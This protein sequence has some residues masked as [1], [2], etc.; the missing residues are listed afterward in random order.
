MARTHRIADRATPAALRSLLKAVLQSR[1]N[2]NGYSMPM[3]MV[4]ALILIVGG[5]AIASR[6]NQGLL[7]AIFQNQSWEAREAAEIGMNRLISDLNRERNRWLMVSR[8]G[9][10]EGTS[11]DTSPW[12]KPASGGSID[13]T[14]RNPCNPETTADYSRLDPSNA[15]SRTYGN[16]Y[17]KND[18][19]VS[20]SSSSATRSYRLLAVERQSMAAMTDLSPFRDR[21]ALPSGVG[22]ITLRV[23]GQKLNSSGTAV[24]TV[25][26]EKTFELVPKCCR[27]S[28][29]G[30][31]GALD[32]QL[33][34]S[35]ESLCVDPTQLGMGLLAGAAQNNTGSITLRGA[36]TDIQTSAGVT[37]DPIYC[38]AD[39]EAGCAISV[40][41][42]QPTGV[43]VV[44]AELPPVKTYPSTPVPSPGSIDTSTAAQFPSTP[45][46]GASA[47]S[48]RFLYQAGSGGS[49][50]YVVNGSFTSA[51]GFPSFCSST[52]TEVHCNLTSF[53]YKNNPV[54]FVTGTRKLRFYFPN[55]G[56]V[57]SQ[58][59]N[60][61]LLHCLTL[62]AAGTCATTPSGAQITNL[63]LFGCSSCSSQSI[64]LRGT[65][66]TLR[67]FSYFPKGNIS[68]YGNSQFEGISWSNQLSS[69]GNPTW[70]VPGS[71]LASVYEYMGMLPASS[72]GSSTS[73]L[74][75]YDFIA[76][77]TNRYRWY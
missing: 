46:S 30:E 71:G 64:T 2:A 35:N 34:A 38:I 8:T 65:T 14:R 25:T 9:D 42:S 59:G 32:Y 16:W 36:A 53:A 51:T 37:V 54:L 20:S 73:S 40:N 56:T 76:R 18:G 60:S 22:T 48:N 47:V 66:D 11:S 58:T 45:T 28:F 44:D 5:V 13:T 24:A 63:S 57:I 31:H 70:T 7:G 50:Y 29:G 72:G 17:I 74:I 61:T 23:Q 33:T 41:G 3:V 27:V 26:L 77:A 62:G 21:G 4:I 12:A 39:N 49:T 68:L 52:A 1:R 55:A 43:A 19:T 67:L 75:A 15:A 69:T 6:A 10:T